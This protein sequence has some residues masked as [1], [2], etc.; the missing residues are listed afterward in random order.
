MM[1][2]SP[3]ERLLGRFL[4]ARQG[5]VRAAQVLAQEKEEAGLM[6]SHRFLAGMTPGIY[7]FAGLAGAII[8]I[9]GL[10]PIFSLAGAIS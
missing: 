6:L 3:H 1:A 4:S 9:A 5:P 8:V 7:L 2:L 10:A